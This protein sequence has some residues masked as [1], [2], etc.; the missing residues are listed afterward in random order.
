[1]NMEQF[2]TNAEMHRPGSPPTI[3]VNL[4][5]PS[6]L[7]CA[8]LH[9]HAV[10]VCVIRNGKKVYVHLGIGELDNERSNWH[11]QLTVV[12]RDA[13]AKV[14]IRTKPWAPVQ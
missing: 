13:D 1:M 9:N 7:R 6:Q 11:A 12:N 3:L 4:D 5:D 2:G 8:M 10:S 14:V